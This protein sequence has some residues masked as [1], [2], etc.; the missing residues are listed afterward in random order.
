MKTHKHI[1]FTTSLP[2]EVILAAGHVPVDLNNRFITTDAAAKISQAE[3]NG[4]P[5]TICSW[6]K[7]N[8]ITA[9]TSGLDEVIGIIQG[10]CSNTHSIMDMLKEDGMPVWHFS[11]PPE[12]NY[13]ALDKEIQRLEEHYQVLRYQSLAQKK[14]LDTIRRRLVYLDE[15]TWKHRLV[16]GAENHSWLISS[17]DFNEDPDRYEEDLEKFISVAENR[18]PLPSRL[19]LAYLGVPPVYNDLYNVVSSL[20]G[21]ILF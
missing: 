21:D 12:K 20:G 1:G 6:I 16:S 13:Q 19:R 3:L 10:D 11:F 5:R 14:R 18:A 4:F 17:S 8:Y 9:R 7:G 2:I 15:L